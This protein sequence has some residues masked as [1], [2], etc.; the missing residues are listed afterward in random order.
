MFAENITKK[1]GKNKQLVVLPGV[2]QLQSRDGESDLR[3]GKISKLDTPTPE[4]VLELSTGRV[5]LVGSILYPHAAFLTLQTNPKQAAVVCDSLYESIIFFSRVVW[6][7]TKEENPDDKDLKW[8]LSLQQG[9][10]AFSS[11]PGD[12]ANSGK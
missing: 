3:I 2:F 5:K 1:H 6:L 9:S 11:A 4:M 7:G 12:R 8:P 10:R